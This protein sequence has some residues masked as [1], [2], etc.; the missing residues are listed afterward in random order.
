VDRESLL[1]LWDQWWDGDVWIA[2]WVRAL[3]GV[4]AE[5]AAWQPTGRDGAPRHSIWQNVAHILLW[6]NVTFDILEGRGR[7]DDAELKARNFAAPAEA[8][9]AAWAASRQALADSHRR[10]RALIADP[11]VPLDRP[12]FHV[13]HDAY[14]LGQ[15]MYIRAMLGLPP[16]DA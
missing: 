3:E 9:E 5:Q 4:S 12:R 6:R 8:T 15:I 1:K 2:P 14:H 13:T 10:M 16:A 11:S 7:P